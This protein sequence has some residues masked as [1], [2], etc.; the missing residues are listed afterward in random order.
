MQCKN[1]KVDQLKVFCSFLFLKTHSHT[2]VCYQVELV[3]F[4]SFRGLHICF[5]QFLL[6]INFIC[7]CHRFLS[8]DFVD[9]YYI[10]LCLFSNCFCYF[11]NILLSST[12]MEMLIIKHATCKL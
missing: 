10:I 7:L 9:P 8:C 3:F 1:N 5:E 6:F 4:F 11:V 12:V 2:L